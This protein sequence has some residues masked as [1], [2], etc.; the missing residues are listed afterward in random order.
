MPEIITRECA[1]AFECARGKET[2]I[3]P[4]AYFGPQG[5]KDFQSARGIVSSTRHWLKKL[6]QAVG[7][8]LADMAETVYRRSTFS[9]KTTLSACKAMQEFNNASRKAHANGILWDEVCLRNRDL[10]GSSLQFPNKN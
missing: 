8:V 5:K 4:Q 1:W 9:M 10:T 7:R 6:H 3:I 2:V